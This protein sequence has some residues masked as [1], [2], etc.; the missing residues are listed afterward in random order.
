MKFALALTGAAIFGA[1]V[2]IA[3]ASAHERIR[4]LATAH[5]RLL[6]RPVYR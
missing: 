3:T 4:T 1:C 5:D 2:G 6:G